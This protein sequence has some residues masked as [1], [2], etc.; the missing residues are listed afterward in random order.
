MRMFIVIGLD[1]QNDHVVKM[2]SLMNQ[3]ARFP[4][5]PRP[6]PHH[7]TPPEFVIFLGGGKKNNANRLGMGWGW[8]ENQN[9]RAKV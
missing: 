6:A 7:T 8:T 4:E 1:D 3:H 2:L 9:I 5:P